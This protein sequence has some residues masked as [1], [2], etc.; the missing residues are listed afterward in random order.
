MTTSDAPEMQSRKKSRSPAAPSRS[1]SECLDDVRRLYE[2]YRHGTFTRAEVASSLGVS[3]T[4][5]PFGSRIFSI[6]EFGLI[7]STGADYRV[8]DLFIEM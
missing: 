6:R 2:T 1:L 7:E 5:G 4:S 3:A 8:S